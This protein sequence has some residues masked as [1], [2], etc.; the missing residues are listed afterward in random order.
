MLHELPNAASVPNTRSRVSEDILKGSEI[1]FFGRAR[2]GPKLI[3]MT[4]DRF[5]THQ[6]SG[7]LAQE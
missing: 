4:K 3:L 7:T 2:S 5:P 1:V 6:I